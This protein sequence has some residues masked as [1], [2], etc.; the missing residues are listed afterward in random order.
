[1]HVCFAVSII[2][3]KQK[4]LLLILFLSDIQIFIHLPIFSP[5]LFFLLPCLNSYQPEKMTSAGLGHKFQV[6]EM[7]TTQSAVKIYSNHQILLIS[8]PI[9]RL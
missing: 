2:G 4:Y 9:N 3:L 1:M 5:S 6:Y 8:R 7:S